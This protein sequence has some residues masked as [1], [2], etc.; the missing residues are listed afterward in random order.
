GFGGVVALVVIMSAPQK[1]LRVGS[2]LPPADSYSSGW[3]HK[4]DFSDVLLGTTHHLNFKAFKDKDLSPERF[5]FKKAR[6][7]L[8]TELLALNE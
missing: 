7:S 2:T 5:C 6:T 3:R 4:L 8:C 1:V